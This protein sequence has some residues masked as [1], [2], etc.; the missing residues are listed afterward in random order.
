MLYLQVV[1]REVIS[2]KPIANYVFP[3]AQNVLLEAAPGPERAGLEN[4]VTATQTLWETVQD[5]GR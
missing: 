3:A 2:L 5:K 1:I 4:R